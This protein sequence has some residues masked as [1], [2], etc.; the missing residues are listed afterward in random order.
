[1]SFEKHIGLV[2]ICPFNTEISNCAFK[3]F[4]LNNSIHKRVLA[5][6]MMSDLELMDLIDK[7]HICMAYREKGLL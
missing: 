3:D 2:F 4:R 1:M 5:W 7:H 6:K